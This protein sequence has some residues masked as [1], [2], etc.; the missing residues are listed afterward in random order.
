MKRIYAYIILALAL[1]ALL[2]ALGVTFVGYKSKGDVALC[3][4]KD[5]YTYIPKHVRLSDFDNHFRH[6]SNITGYDW[7]LIAAIAYTE[8]RFDST[9]V[10]K[11]GARGVMQVMPNTLS[12]F[13]IPDSMHMDSKTNIMVATE[14]LKALDRRF[15]YIRNPKERIN[16]V[17][18]SYNAGYGHVQDAMQLAKK[19]GKNRFVW[20]NSVDSFL[21]Y[22]S[23]PEYY[24]DS[25]CRN[26]QFNGW[27][28][29]LSFVNKVHRNWRRFEKMQKQYTDSIMLVATNDS[30]IRIK[31]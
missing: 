4:T 19:H 20:H 15:R 5:S 27:R 2:I 31:E 16:F 28:E 14:L 6:A 7:T 24:T 3:A 29:T 9:A 18:A 10:S 11:A 25:V 1:L 13:N 17:L 22:K 30:T 8:S 12:S 21:I 26:G 23:K